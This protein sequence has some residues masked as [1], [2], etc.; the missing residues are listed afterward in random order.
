MDKKDE[1]E[2]EEDSE[3]SEE[4]PSQEE[5]FEDEDSVESLKDEDS[6]ETL[7]DEDSEESSEDEDSEETIEE[8]KPEE[9]Y[10][11]EEPEEPE[12]YAEEIAKVEEVEPATET[13]AGSRGINWLGIIAIVLGVSGLFVGYSAKRSISNLR[14]DTEQVTS[15][16]G[17]LAHLEDQVNSI[18][19]RL[20]NVGAET[21]K[22]KK[23]IRS[24]REHVVRTLNS[25]N[26]EIILGQNQVSTSSTQTDRSAGGRIT[27]ARPDSTASNQRKA[28]STS[29]SAVPA[30]GYHVIRPGDT[31]GKLARQYGITVN[32]IFQANP[33]ADPR[34]LQI[35]QR[36]LIPK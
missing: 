1:W 20:I 8:D 17:K 9:S 27:R 23:D 5:F 29:T 4:T 36:I 19:R 18:E 32:A 6:E 7:E 22:I 13:L 33:K 35:G 16:K 3:K 15:S 14:M 28:V 2:Y 26:Q 24:V 11:V 34:R 30:S 31:F 25:I 12:H 10:V 21:V